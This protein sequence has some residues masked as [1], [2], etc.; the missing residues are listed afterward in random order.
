MGER[1]TGMGIGTYELCAKYVAKSLEA[2]KEGNIICKA[3]RI[4]VTSPLCAAG[5]GMYVAEPEVTADA[6][7]RDAISSCSSARCVVC[8]GGTPHV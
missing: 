6:R 1:D 5:L 8:A 4:R 7:S 3:V 2:E